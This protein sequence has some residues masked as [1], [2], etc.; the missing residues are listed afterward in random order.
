MST[1]DSQITQL[2]AAR[3]GE[4]YEKSLQLRAYSMALLQ[5]SR[6]LCNDSRRLRAINKFLALNNANPNSARKRKPMRESALRFASRPQINFHI[7]LRSSQQQSNEPHFK[8]LDE[9]KLLY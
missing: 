3:D 8:V 4:L 6:N 1:N 2:Q 5:E 9:T 7:Q